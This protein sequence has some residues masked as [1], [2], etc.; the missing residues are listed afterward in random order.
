MRGGVAL[1]L[2]VLAALIAV[3]DGAT[4]ALDL[5][6]TSGNEIQSGNGLLDFYLLDGVTSLEEN[7]YG[8]FDADGAARLTRMGEE[9]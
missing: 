5:I 4:P 9:T 6:P 3:Q 2:F 1:A 7:Q 8:T